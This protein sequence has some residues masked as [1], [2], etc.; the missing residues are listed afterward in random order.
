MT[1]ARRKEARGFTL[2]ELAVV[3]TIIGILAMLAV[4]GYRKL[5]TS[6]HTSEATEMVNAIKVAQETYHSETG[7]YANISAA[8]G[9]G[10]LY[11]QATPDN[12]TA[13]AWGGTC[14]VCTDQTGWQK[15]PVHASGPVRFGYATMAG[16]VSTP[17]PASPIGNVT[18]PANN[19]LT[20]DWYVIDAM[21]DM[22]GNSVYCTVVG[23]SWQRDLY[24]DKEGE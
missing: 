21:G 19:Q 11:P 2:I 4:A 20:G 24:V 18:F 7:Q 15:L 23:V 1:R 9:L 17:L 6:S 3:V 12:K 13:T 22:D 8:L 10:N 16:N 14:G 5:I